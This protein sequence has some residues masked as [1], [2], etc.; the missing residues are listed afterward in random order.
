MLFLWI[1][2][3]LNKRLYSCCWIDLPQHAD[4]AAGSRRIA[5]CLLTKVL[6]L[7][8]P[9]V[10]ILSK[11]SYK[12][13]SVEGRVTGR[14]SSWKGFFLYRDTAVM[15]ATYRLKKQG[16]NHHSTHYIQIWVKKVFVYIRTLLFD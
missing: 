14:Q 9:T 16:S 3:L 1:A 4:Q 12:V 2:V 13:Q 10:H 6:I 11:Y 7:Q 5:P 8:Q 15:T